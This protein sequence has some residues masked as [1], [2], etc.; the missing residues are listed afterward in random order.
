MSNATLAI[1]AGVLIVPFLLLS[2]GGNWLALLAVLPLFAGLGI[3]IGGSLGLLVHALVS[4]TEHA[5]A[6]SA[7]WV[8]GLAVVGALSLHSQYLSFFEATTACSNSAYTEP[9]VILAFD[10]ASEQQFDMLLE[11]ELAAASIW[12]RYRNSLFWGNSNYPP[13]IHGDKF[14]TYGCNLTGNFAH[15]VQVREYNASFWI[16]HATGELFSWSEE[17]DFWSDAHSSIKVQLDTRSL[18]SEP[19]EQ[20]ILPTGHVLKFE[21]EDKEVPNWSFSTDYHGLR[22]RFDIRGGRDFPALEYAPPI[23]SKKQTT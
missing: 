21:F 18:Y 7:T 15:P 8:V 4:W 14:S 11:P 17:R 6:K 20:L 10:G 1:G 3:I 13:I 2:A 19:T 16:D 12:L 5:V 22:M 9:R 23:F